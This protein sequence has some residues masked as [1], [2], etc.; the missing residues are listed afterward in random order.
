MNQGK[1]YTILLII[2]SLIVYLEWGS[3]Q[4]MF[5]VQM[6]YEIILK[7]LSHPFSILHPFIVLPFIGQMM[8]IITLLQKNPSK[9]LTYF[10]VIGLGLLIAFIFIIGL[11]SFNLKIILYS[12]P[13]II[14]SIYRFL[15]LK[16]S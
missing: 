14:L 3:E 7:S 2:A 4:K 8:L 16:K 15:Q 10:G 6:E 9:F 5:L 1:F 11:I 12:L 13:F